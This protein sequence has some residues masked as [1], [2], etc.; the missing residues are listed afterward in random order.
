MLRYI[1]VLWR[2]CLPLCL[3]SL[4][5]TSCVGKGKYLDALQLG[6]EARSDAAVAKTD[7]A[8][9][10]RRVEQLQRSYRHLLDSLAEQTTL[11][12]QERSGSLDVQQSLKTTN[13]LQALLIDSLRTERDQLYRQRKSALSVLERYDTRLTALQSRITKQVGP[14]LP[15]PIRSIRSADQL[16]VFLPEASLFVERRSPAVSPAG[17]ATLTALASALGG[18]S[19]LRVEV[20][21]EPRDLSG[22]PAARVEAGRRAALVVSNLVEG[23][24]L[25]PAIVAATSLQAD[26]TAA[27]L[28]PAEFGAV[29]DT[30]I[31]VR[32]WIAGDVAGQ[33]LQALKE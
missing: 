7:H 1:Q 31:R 30:H 22:S 6:A 13:A 10:M 15:T 20:A 28:A 19:D 3:L 32:I 2:Q 14:T 12:L 17:D 24:G 5:L 18:Q 23:H 11:Q 21:A 9:A 27:A 16:T 33:V 29:N 26:A 4:L 8:D 25:D